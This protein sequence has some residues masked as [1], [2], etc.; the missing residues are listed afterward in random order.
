MADVGS[1][2]S[3]RKTGVSPGSPVITHYRRPVSPSASTSRHRR[4][5]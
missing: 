1:L 3:M 5:R 4:V 2:K